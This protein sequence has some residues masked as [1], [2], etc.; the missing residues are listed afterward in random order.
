MCMCGGFPSLLRHA[1]SI[2]C[3]SGGAVWRSEGAK[4]GQHKHR[5]PCALCW[6]W[7]IGQV[8]ARRPERCSQTA[9]GSKEFSFLFFL[10]VTSSWIYKDERGYFPSTPRHLSVK[11]SKTNEEKTNGFQTGAWE[12]IFHMGRLQRYYN[13]GRPFSISFILAGSFERVNRLAGR[14]TGKDQAG[15]VLIYIYIYVR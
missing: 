7:L 9:V 13:S 11:V 8:R 14:S 15:R 3:L 12:R 6:W 10:M 2:R 5:G 1:G 4:K